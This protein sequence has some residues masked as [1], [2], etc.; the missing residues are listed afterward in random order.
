MDASASTAYGMDC[1]A[2]AGPDMAWS[3]QAWLGMGC[4]Q[5]VVSSMRMLPDAISISY[6]APRWGKVGLAWMR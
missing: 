4:Q 2:M 3:G 5:Q 1:R 6:G